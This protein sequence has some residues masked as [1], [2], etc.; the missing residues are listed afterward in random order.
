MRRPFLTL[1]LLAALPGLLLSCGSGS[2]RLGAVAA[3]QPVA[4][5][6]AAA[7]DAFYDG[8]ALPAGELAAGRRS[9]MDGCVEP[10]PTRALC[11]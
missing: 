2:I 9:R 8:P 4:A 6:I 1:S 5:P 11:R 3:A 7:A 10:G